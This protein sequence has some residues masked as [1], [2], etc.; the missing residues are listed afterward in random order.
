MYF[1]AGTSIDL[2]MSFGIWSG[3]SDSGE[4]SLMKSK[5]P[6]DMNGPVFRKGSSRVT[7]FVAVSVFSCLDVVVGTLGTALICVLYGYLVYAPAESAFTAPACVGPA[8]GTR[9]CGSFLVTSDSGVTANPVAYLIH[10]G[11]AWVPHITV[12]RLLTA[13]VS[14][15]A[16]CRYLAESQGG[17][18]RN[19]GSDNPRLARLETTHGERTNERKIPAKFNVTNDA[20]PG[21]A[22]MVEAPGHATA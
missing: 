22:V 2:S 12:T 19:G 16:P 3:V 17:C 14:V 21:L 4:R 10:A 8:C 11:G 18:A 15:S 20:P 7:I 6:A 5:A 9:P 13:A 1:C